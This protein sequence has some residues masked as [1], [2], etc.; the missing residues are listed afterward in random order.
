MS[1]PALPHCYY[2][3]RPSDGIMHIMP[4][5]TA[6]NQIFH[7]PTDFY[8]VLHSSNH[9][10][11]H[12]Q[13]FSSECLLPLKRKVFLNTEWSQCTWSYLHFTNITVIKQAVITSWSQCQSLAQSEWSI[14]QQKQETNRSRK[15]NSKLQVWAIRQKNQGKKKK[16]RSTAAS[17]TEKERSVISVKWLGCSSR[18]E[19]TTAFRN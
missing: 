15:L 4:L 1:R 18:L 19:R 16:K 17:H 10:T 6:A 8:L 11:L 7:F 13:P 3:I 9:Y 12:F 14:R 5:A 2:T